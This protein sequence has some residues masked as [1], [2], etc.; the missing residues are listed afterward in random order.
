MWRHITL[1]W[2]FTGHCLH[3]RVAYTF[4]KTEKA[5]W[6]WFNTVICFCITNLWEIDCVA[7]NTEGGEGETA[8]SPSCSDS[9]WWSLR[10]NHHFTE[11]LK[12]QA[13]KMSRLHT[14]SKACLFLLTAY[15]CDRVCY[16]MWLYCLRSDR[17]CAVAF[18][19]LI[20]GRFRL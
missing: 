13:V 15:R 8:T 3:H 4:R 1:H 7:C 16:C 14:Q 5:L 20:H 17:H 12:T 6:S 11:K 18:L 10:K 2:D 19:G 9:V